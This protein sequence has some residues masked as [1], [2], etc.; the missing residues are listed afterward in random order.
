[1]SDENYS[2]VGSSKQE[3]N[4][5]SGN[6]FLCFEEQLEKIQK[7]KSNVWQVEMDVYVSCIASNKTSK[8]KLNGYR[9]TQKYRRLEHESRTT[10][11]FWSEVY[12]CLREVWLYFSE[13]NSDGGSTLR[14]MF[15][16]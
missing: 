15:V 16:L 4:I 14:E 11:G 2:Q 5:E 3:S 7:R 9:E 12:D 13:A 8:E 10:L 1:M 6:R